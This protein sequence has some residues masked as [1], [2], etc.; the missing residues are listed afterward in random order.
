[1]YSIIFGFRKVKA[2]AKFYA[3]FTASD[4]TVDIRLKS[5]KTISR[6]PSA[7]AA[8]L[9]QRSPCAVR[10]LFEKPADYSSDF[11]DLIVCY[12][13][14]NSQYNGKASIFPTFMGKSLL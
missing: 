9:F 13:Y 10:T 12:I 11:A 4:H 8:R 5:K 2:F 14:Y 1:M 7:T 3:D 6:A